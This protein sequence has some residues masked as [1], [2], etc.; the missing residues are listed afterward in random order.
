MV[1]GDRRWYKGIVGG[2]RGLEVVQGDWRRY[3]VIECGKSGWRWY[4]GIGGG[5]MG[6]KVEKRDWTWYDRIVK[7]PLY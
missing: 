4:K 2:T 6:L 1:Q 3:K 7:H 5:T